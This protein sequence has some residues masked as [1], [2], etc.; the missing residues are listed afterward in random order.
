M[1][2]KNDTIDA[3][4]RLNPTA[5]PDFLAGFSSDELYRYLDRLTGTSTRGQASDPIHDVGLGYPAAVD[6]ALPTHALRS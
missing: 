5:N 1:M 3:I 2:T 6:A 4:R